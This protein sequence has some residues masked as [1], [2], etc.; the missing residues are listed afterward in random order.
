[1]Q[2]PFDYIEKSIDDPSYDVENDY[3]AMNEVT[4][5]CERCNATFTLEEAT[6]QFYDNTHGANYFSC[7]NRGELCGD[8]AAE[9]YDKTPIL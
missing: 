4:Y 7:G 8:C 9:D 6:S 2:G 1:M 5:T 3:E